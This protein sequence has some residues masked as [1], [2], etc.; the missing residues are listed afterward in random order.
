[1]PGQRCN[2]AGLSAEYA[3]QGLTVAL[4]RPLIAP[5]DIIKEVVPKN[6]LIIDTTAERG[7]EFVS[8]SHVRFHLIDL[9]RILNLQLEEIDFRLRVF[10]K[11]LDLLPSLRRPIFQHF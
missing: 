4:N 2:E 10:R 6:L 7:A 5:H 1:M 8:E 11:R 3:M 9:I